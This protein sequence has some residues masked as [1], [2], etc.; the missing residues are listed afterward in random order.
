MDRS[1]DVRRLLFTLGLPTLGLAFSLSILT[2]YGP[3]LLLRIA[4]SP[5]RVGALI[6]GEGAFALSIP[7]LAGALSDRLPMSPLGRRM[8]FMLIGMPLVAAGLLLLPWAPNYPMAG[9]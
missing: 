2:T 9:M 6:G 8:P 7:L 3:L 5:A 4:H 1:P